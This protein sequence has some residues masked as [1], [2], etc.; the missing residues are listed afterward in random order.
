MAVSY[1]ITVSVAEIQLIKMN[2]YSAAMLNATIMHGIVLC[3]ELW[4]TLTSIK[5]IATKPVIYSGSSSEL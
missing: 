1:F 3:M 5:M 2:T 4:T